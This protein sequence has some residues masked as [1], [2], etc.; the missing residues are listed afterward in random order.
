MSR[1][2][3]QRETPGLLP[4]ITEGTRIRTDMKTIGGLISVLLGGCT[5]CTVIYLDVQGLKDSKREQ[6]TKIEQLTNQVADMR[7]ELHRISWS[8]GIASKAVPA[9]GNP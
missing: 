2:A 6:S 9:K 7:D 4:S 1:S 5:F 8:L 3:D